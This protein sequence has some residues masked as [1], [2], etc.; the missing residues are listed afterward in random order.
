[1]S[2]VALILHYASDSSASAF[3]FPP[4]AEPLA[5][6]GNLDRKIKARFAGD[7]RLLEDRQ[8]NG[9]KELEVFSI[10]P[11]S[12]RSRRV[13][14]AANFTQLRDE[15]QGSLRVSR[16][17]FIDVHLLED[18]QENGEKELK[19]FSLSLFSCRSRQAAVAANFTQ[20]RF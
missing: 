11:F 8:E 20:L 6:A 10:S 14:V 17:K 2:P 5:L 9:E 19:I 1:M 13:A 15:G 18:P 12:C 4:T 3:G 7:V 16:K